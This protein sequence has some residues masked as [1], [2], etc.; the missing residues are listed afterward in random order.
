MSST[1]PAHPLDKI[2]V[3]QQLRQAIG[4]R[5]GINRAG[6]PSRRSTLVN[7]YDAGSEEFS[8]SI[9]INTFVAL[10]SPIRLNS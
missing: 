5:K 8:V 3:P 2:G 4:N 9:H 6:C 10:E 7:G 1:V